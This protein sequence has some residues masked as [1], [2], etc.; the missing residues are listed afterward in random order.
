MNMNTL[1]K[2]K[3]QL[4]CLLLT[5]LVSFPLTYCAN[6]K[7]K[8]FGDDALE[9]VVPP[10]ALD[11]IYL[12][13]T[14]CGVHGTMN[15]SE[16]LPCGAETGASPLERADKTCQTE[17]ARTMDIPGM[18]PILPS[19]SDAERMN[20]EA[21]KTPVHRAFLAS[22]GNLPQNFLLRGRDSLDVRRPVDNERISDSWADFFQ[23]NQDTAVPI[24]TTISRYYHTGLERSGDSFVLGANCE[25][26]TNNG[27]AGDPAVETSIR[28]RATN[29]DFRRI[30][31]AGGTTGLITGGTGCVIPSPSTFSAGNDRLLCISH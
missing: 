24:D 4:L 29:V 9:E 2:T 31:V 8:A 15:P 22:S 14:G 25:D 5:G 17:Y 20:I 21:G 3:K 16:A 10:A 30:E 13:V 27:S 19:L 23:A 28:G 18:P 12:W 7:G 11:A 1:Q 26:W 6:V